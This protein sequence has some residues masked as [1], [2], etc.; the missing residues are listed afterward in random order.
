MKTQPRQHISN[1]YNTCTVVTS[2]VSISSKAVNQTFEC[3]EK[4]KS[5]IKRRIDDYVRTQW[6]QEPKSSFKYL[7]VQS[8][9]VG[10][11]HQ[12]WRSLPNDVRV[13][14]RAYS[15]LRLLTETY[16]LQENRA[17]FIQHAVDNTEGPILRL[18]CIFL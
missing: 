6:F 2:P 9:H 13:V 18:L 17:R 3:M 16:I 5:E 15:K 7:N 1:K 12:S 10:E 4:W 14:K 8:L 11:I